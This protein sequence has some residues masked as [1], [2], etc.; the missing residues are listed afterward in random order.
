[1]GGQVRDGK[2]DYA[3]E[4]N[5]KAGNAKAGDAKAGE[6]LARAAGEVPG[7][8]A[9]AGATPDRA[10]IASPA[11][12]SR[13][14]GARAASPPGSNAA[15][16]RAPGGAPTGPMDAARHPY[17]P[18][19]VAALV[20]GI[21]RAA[22]KKRSPAGAQV[23][24]DWAGIVGPELAAVT[25]PRRL[26]AGTLTLACSGPTAMELQHLSGQVIERVNGHLGRILVERLRFVQDPS[27]PAVAVRPP[28]RRAAAAI[29]LPGIP[30]GPLRDAL[31]ALG[32]VVGGQ[33]GASVAVAGRRPAR[34]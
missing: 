1:M 25:V 27:P 26:T 32:Q 6:G 11:S 12:A 18:R 24:A 21:T 20:P 3:K 33:S 19:P 34:P 7:T 30:P 17:G 2:P 16:A 15:G 9:C 28:P 23:L 5:A 14:A 4:G 29:P 8:V 13:A 10:A 22:F 31:S